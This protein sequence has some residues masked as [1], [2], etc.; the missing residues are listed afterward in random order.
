[1]APNHRQGEALIERYMPNVTPEEQEAA[2]TNLK[3]YLRTLIRIA[4]RLEQERR[5]RPSEPDLSQ[6][7]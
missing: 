3:D 2:L 6:R 5:D 1:M 7:H 4:A